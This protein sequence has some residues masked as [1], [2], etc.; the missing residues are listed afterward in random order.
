MVNDAKDQVRQAIGDGG[1]D[2]RN[3]KDLEVPQ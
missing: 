3:A 1:E 2:C